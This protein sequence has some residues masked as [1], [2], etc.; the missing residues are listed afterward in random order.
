MQYITGRPKNH[1]SSPFKTGEIEQMTK[2][3]WKSSEFLH[4][5]SVWPPS[6]Q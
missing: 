4:V 6:M 3:Q 1:P 2:Q 5:V